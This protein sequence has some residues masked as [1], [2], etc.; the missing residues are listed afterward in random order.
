MASRWT[1]EPSASKHINVVAPQQPEGHC[2]SSTFSG[3]H[4]QRNVYLLFM[5]WHCVGVGQ[6]LSCGQCFSPIWTSWRR[7]SH[8]LRLTSEG[9]GRT[10][11]AGMLALCSCQAQQVFN[12]ITIPCH[13]SQ[14]CLLTHIFKGCMCALF[15][16]HE[17]YYKCMHILD[18]RSPA[19]PDAL[20][21]SLILTWEIGLCFLP[22]PGCPCLFQSNFQF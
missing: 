7:P 21:L 2:T 13:M 5:S 20:N 1:T 3:L 8:P 9:V 15:L 18:L 6:S 10:K 17:K 22:S 14:R 4:P 16:I 19:M 12:R 11:W